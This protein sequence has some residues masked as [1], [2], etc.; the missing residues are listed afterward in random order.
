MFHRTKAGVQFLQYFKDFAKHC[1]HSQNLIIEIRFTQLV[2][3]GALNLAK[4]KNLAKAGT[5]SAIS[6]LIV[7]VTYFL[8]PQTTNCVQN[9]TIYLSKHSPCQMVTLSFPHIGWLR[10]GEG[11]S[12]AQWKTEVLPWAPVGRWTWTWTWWTCPRV[13]RWLFFYS[14]EKYQSLVQKPQNM[15]PKILPYKGP[16]GPRSPKSHTFIPRTP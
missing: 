16:L 13:R 9:Y 3:R 7:H 11:Q 1:F 12:L 8:M 4:T 15:L 10:Q 5:L 6:A 14:L 2:S